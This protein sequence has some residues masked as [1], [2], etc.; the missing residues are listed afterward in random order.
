MNI[1]DQTIVD[2]LHIAFMSAAANADVTLLGSV[3]EID[4]MIN[5]RILMLGSGE[6]GENLFHAVPLEL[7]ALRNGLERLVLEEIAER[8]S[9]KRPDE[10]DEQAWEGMNAD[11]KARAY[12]EDLR[13]EGVPPAQW[14]RMDD[15]RRAALGMQSLVEEWDFRG[16]L[17]GIKPAGVEPED[18]AIVARVMS[19]LS[20]DEMR[21][22]I[23][24]GF[25]AGGPDL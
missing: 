6:D 5:D 9:P 1:D 16:S 23:E 7:D 19:L 18:L 2:I 13:P 14:W 12:S 22:L 21:A 25:H 17:S 15:R 20:R 10:I 4:S 24:R 11:A 3:G 8:R